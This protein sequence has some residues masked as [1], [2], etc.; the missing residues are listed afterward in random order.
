MDVYA[1]A[2]APILLWRRYTY[3]SR[4]WPGLTRCYLYTVRSPRFILF[5]DSRGTN[6]YFARRPHTPSDPPTHHPVV[7]PVVFSRAPIVGC[8]YRRDERYIDCVESWTMY[9]TPSRKVCFIIYTIYY[10]VNILYYIIDSSS[11]PLRF[12]RTSYTKTA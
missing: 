2:R 3:C 4:A 11:S 1:R 7:C 12:V 9:T 10:I 5:R 6:L 8:I